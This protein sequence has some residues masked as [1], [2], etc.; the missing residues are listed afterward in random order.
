MKRTKV[1]YI[2]N[3]R[4]ITLAGIAISALALCL[5]GCTAAGQPVHVNIPG[6]GDVG[7]SFQGQI[8]PPAY[9]APA[10]A[11]PATYIQPPQ[12][13]ASFGVQAQTPL[14]PPQLV[15]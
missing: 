7:F 9:N 15:K 11:A 13:T 4:K 6:I 2:K 5:A 3:G 1:H 12:A 14:I 8:I 10:P